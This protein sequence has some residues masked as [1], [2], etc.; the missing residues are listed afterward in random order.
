[1]RV[2]EV[3]KGIYL[4]NCDY[5]ELLKT[6]GD[7]SFDLAI[8]DPPYFDGPNTRRYYGSS[9]STRD[10]KRREYDTIEG[11]EVPDQS[12]FKELSRVSHNQIIWGINY[13]NFGSISSGRIIWDKVNGASSFSDCEIA[14]CSVHGSVRLFPFMWNGMM[15]GK[16][17]R[18]GRAMQG[19]KKL[20]EK[21]IHPTQK[22]VA[23][24]DWI[25]DRYARSGDSIL[26]THLGSGS[27][28][29]SAWKAGHVLHGCEK[30]PVIFEKALRR[31]ELETK[32]LKLFQN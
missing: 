1:M 9:V 15:Q 26:D 20:N 6:S 19:N 29:I 3:R 22:P 2:V 7:K 16:S 24:Y 21:R 18:D 13:F 12:Y 23:L 32:Q 27:I 8:C 11:W 28:A 5:R 4:Y 10:V 31:I 14:Y 30:D 25:I 17:I